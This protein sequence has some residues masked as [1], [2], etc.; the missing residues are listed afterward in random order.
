[1][2]DAERGTVSFARRD[3]AFNE[4]MDVPR[5]ELPA[6]LLAVL[7][8]MQSG[9]FERAK[10]FRAANMHPIASRDE[11][12]AFFT[13]KSAERPEIHGGSGKCVVCGREKQATAVFAKSY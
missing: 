11:F 2:R 7:A 6:R 10:S 8:E 4:K 13:P 12:F 3:R 9:L 5:A 1:P